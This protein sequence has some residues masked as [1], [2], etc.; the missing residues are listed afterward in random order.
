M[1]RTPDEDWIAV[2]ELD[3]RI[4]MDRKT[5]RIRFGRTGPPVAL[6]STVVAI[7]HGETTWNAVERRNSAFPAYFRPLPCGLIYIQILYTQ[8]TIPALFDIL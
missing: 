3:G 1:T 2:P 7:R 8:L 6:D 4:L 5:G